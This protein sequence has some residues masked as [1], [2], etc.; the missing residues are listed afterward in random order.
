MYVRNKIPLDTALI[1][2]YY[3]QN[4]YN[5]IEYNIILNV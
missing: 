1:S 3:K 4:E 5:F 2:I